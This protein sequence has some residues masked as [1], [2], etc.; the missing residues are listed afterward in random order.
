MGFFRFLRKLFARVL[1]VAMA[2]VAFS[3]IGRRL[4][5]LLSLRNSDV[6]VVV[7]SSRV[8]FCVSVDRLFMGRLIPLLPSS[9]EETFKLEFWVSSFDG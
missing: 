4:L 5:M 3:L 6:V 7:A 9:P 1:A 2:S 8:D